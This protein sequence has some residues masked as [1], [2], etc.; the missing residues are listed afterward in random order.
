VRIRV[1]TIASAG[2][3]FGVSCWRKDVVD[4]SET[5][6]SIL[7]H[8]KHMDRRNIHGVITTA[9]FLNVA[10]TFRNSSISHSV[11][12]TSR[13]LRI[14][15]QLCRSRHLM[16]MINRR[17]QIFC[18]QTLQSDTVRVALFIRCCPLASCSRTMM[19]A[20]EKTK[21]ISGMTE[22]Y[23]WRSGNFSSLAKSCSLKVFDSETD[24]P[25]AFIT[26]PG[27][28]VMVPMCRRIWRLF[29]DI[30]QLR[31]TSSKVPMVNLRLPRM[32]SDI[33]AISGQTVVC[34]MTHAS[35]PMHPPCRS[36]NRH[37]RSSIV[38]S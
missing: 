24:Y 29:S 9:W 38:P 18:S 34:Q 15:W 21:D 16:T 6:A 17:Q 4:A 13:P 22:S 5:K 37:T 36:D 27:R 8:V 2:R 12:P 10:L 3:R 11:I 19:T 1:A 26:V 33:T 7:L 28:S 31:K 30:R 20:S 25:S 14:W 32:V 23:A 35:I